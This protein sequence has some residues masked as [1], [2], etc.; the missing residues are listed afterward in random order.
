MNPVRAPE[1]VFLSGK[2]VLYAPKRS[3]QRA[4]HLY[5]RG[6]LWLVRT[7]NAVFA[8]GETMREVK[9]RWWSLY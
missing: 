5:R 7:S 1:K 2:S 9:L 6:G 4:P 8:M 3:L